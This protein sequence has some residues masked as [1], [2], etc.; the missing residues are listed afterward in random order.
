MSKLLYQEQEQEQEQEQ[1]QQ[2]KSE[3]TKQ[4]LETEASFLDYLSSHPAPKERLMRM[5]TTEE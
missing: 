2:N 3:K 5:N 1:G 4:P